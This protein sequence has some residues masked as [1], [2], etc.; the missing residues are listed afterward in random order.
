MPGGGESM[1]ARTAIQDIWEIRVCSGS[2][3]LRNL[4]EIS[5]GHYI[6]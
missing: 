6:K 2:E 3:Q 4:Y 5:V 1:Q